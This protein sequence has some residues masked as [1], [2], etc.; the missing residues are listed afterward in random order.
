M[1]PSYLSDTTKELT[2]SIGFFIEKT[3]NES[4]VT[5]NIFDSLHDSFQNSINDWVKLNT[6]DTINYH[7]CYEVEKIIRE[8]LLGN[9]DTIN[10]LRINTEYTFNDLHKIRLKIAEVCGDDLKNILIKTQEKE[11]KELKEEINHL[12]KYI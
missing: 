10:K 7:I 6:E 8:L 4:K 1:I 12:R 3:I 5:K 2:N 11:I 9:L